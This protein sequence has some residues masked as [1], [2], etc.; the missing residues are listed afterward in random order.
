MAHINENE[1]N[2]CHACRNSIKTNGGGIASAVYVCRLFRG[3][4]LAVKGRP[5]AA[6]ELIRAGSVLIAAQVAL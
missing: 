1:S 5:Y 4:E 2:I 6:G 3:L